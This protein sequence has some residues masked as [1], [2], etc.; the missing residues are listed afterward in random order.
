MVLSYGLYGVNYDITLTGFKIY[1]LIVCL[2]KREYQLAKFYLQIL[3]EL[4]D[5]RVLKLFGI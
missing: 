5:F 2:V 3:M 4:V 1:E